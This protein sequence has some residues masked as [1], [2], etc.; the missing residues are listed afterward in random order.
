VSRRSHTQTRDIVSRSR[1]CKKKCDQRG[2]VRDGRVSR[3]K[4]RVTRSD[5]R[6]EVRRHSVEV[7]ELAH[8]RSHPGDALPRRKARPCSTA[9][10]A[11]AAAASARRC[12]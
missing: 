11:F 4:H 10:S 1:R 3:S 12:G 6:F 8:T 7:G 9:P 5:D 2:G